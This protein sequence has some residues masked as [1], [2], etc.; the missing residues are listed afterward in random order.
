MVDFS[1]NDAEEYGLTAYILVIRGGCRQIAARGR[2]K[3]SEK[4]P[5]VRVCTDIDFALGKACSLGL[6][7][8]LFF[9]DGGHPRACRHVEIPS[10]TRG[11]EEQEFASVAFEI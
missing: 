1:A 4:E 7:L 5:R 2:Q 10:T 3:V 9:Q 11:G 6:L 8:G